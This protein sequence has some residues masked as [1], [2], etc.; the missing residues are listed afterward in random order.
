[1]NN[2][3]TDLI[4]QTYHFPQAGFKVE[5]NHLWFNNIPIKDL[6]QQFGTPLKLT[7][8]P[9]I[10]EQI[11]KAREYFPNYRIISSG[12]VK[13]IAGRIYISPPSKM[14]GRDF[15]ILQN[16]RYLIL[17][18]SSFSWWGAWTNQI[19]EVVIAPKY[20]AAYNVSKSFWST[21]EIAEPTWIWKG[22]EN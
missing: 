3:Y 11:E 14:I 1:M 17:S 13:I 7:Y 2:K 4:H 9:K 20:W 15:A 5:D 21:A 18:N 16:A 12:G 19:A 22:R 10:G 8:I 6:V